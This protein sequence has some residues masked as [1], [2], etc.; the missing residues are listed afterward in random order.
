VWCP[1]WLCEAWRL[2]AFA[3]LRETLLK[4]NLVHVTTQSRKAMTAK[5]DGDARSVSH[6]F[7]C[8]TPRLNGHSFLECGGLTPLS[9]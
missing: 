4:T 9:C 3:P 8:Y 7:V 2:C 5:Q 1:V 6:Y